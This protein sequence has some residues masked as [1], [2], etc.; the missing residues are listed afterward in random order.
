MVATTSSD[1]FAAVKNVLHEPDTQTTGDASR[2]KR[3]AALHAAKESDR[4][5]LSLLKRLDTS[6]QD[7]K[8]RRKRAPGN[9]RLAVVAQSQAALHFGMTR[10]PNI[11]RQTIATTHGQTDL[12]AVALP[13]ANL[14]P[15][16]LFCRMIGHISREIAG[17]HGVKIESSLITITGD[18][19]D[20]IATS[21]VRSLYH[22][23]FVMPPV[24][25]H[26]FD[27]KRLLKFPP[28]SWAAAWSSRR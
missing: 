4:E 13:P 14:S 1:A 10:A 7:E 11:W 3:I 12:L 25:N 5:I 19:N 21:I 17:H 28:L 23:T 15:N 22:E 26:W 20:D 6:K 8:P 27:L 16:A 9:T 24:E 2:I 18:K